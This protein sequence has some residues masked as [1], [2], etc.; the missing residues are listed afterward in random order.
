[1]PKFCWMKKGII[2]S[3]ST[4]RQMK[5]LS[6]SR[7]RMEDTRTAMTISR[8][9]RYT[10]NTAGRRRMMGTRSRSLRRGDL[11]SCFIKRFLSCTMMCIIPYHTVKSSPTQEKNHSAAPKGSGVRACLPK[12]SQSLPP[13]GGK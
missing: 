3:T 8:S 9:T 5:A 7:R 1:M 10:A 6:Y 2:N 13:A 11:G 12:A 4:S